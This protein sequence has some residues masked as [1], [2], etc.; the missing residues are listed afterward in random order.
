MNEA[1]RLAMNEAGHTAQSLAERVGVDRKTTTRWLVKDHVPH[2]AHRTAAADA[3]GVDKED[4]WPDTSRRRNP[5]WFRPWQEFEREAT[6]LRSYQPLVVPGLLQTEAYARAVLSSGGLRGRTAVDRLVATRLSRQSILTRED[7]PQFAAV[8]DEVALRR[9]VGGRDAMREQV[10]ALLA[11][12]AAPHI[13]LHVVPLT[14][15]A[16]AGLNGPFVIGT[17]ADHR[18]AVYLDS[19]LEGEMVGTP[20]DVA[21]ILEVWENVRGEALSHW[22]SVDLLR[23]VA[24][25]WT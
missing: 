17:G 19:Q 11:A 13:R 2:P 9:P 4:I 10:S 16:Y 22:Q 23:E 8:V 18:M 12:C 25:S 20:N 3:L 1:L 6:S 21:A 5:V 14:V 15:G 7:P 24:E